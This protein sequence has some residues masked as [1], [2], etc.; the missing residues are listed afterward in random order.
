MRRFFSGADPV[1]TSDA[2]DITA[3]PASKRAGSPN[4]DTPDDGTP[5][6]LCIHWWGRLVRRFFGG[7]SPIVGSSYNVIRRSLNERAEVDG[8]TPMPTGGK[9]TPLCNACW[10]RRLR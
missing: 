2:H 9:S 8:G 3:V 5:Q 4:A 6:A 10:E 1:T 7:E